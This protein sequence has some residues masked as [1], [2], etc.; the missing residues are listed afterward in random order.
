MRFFALLFLLLTALSGPQNHHYHLQ[1]S[2]QMG[3]HEGLSIAHF[4]REFRRQ[5]S[6]SALHLQQRFDRF[7]VGEGAQVGVGLVHGRH[8]GFKL[9]LPF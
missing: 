4:G 9:R 5:D 7:D 1:S 3:S 6:G 8:L 2:T